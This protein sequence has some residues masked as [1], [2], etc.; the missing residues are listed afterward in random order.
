MIETI[1]SVTQAPICVDVN[2][3]W[4]DRQQALDM[5]YWL[6]DRGVVFVEQPLPKE[7]VDDTAW[8]TQHSPLPIIADE[9]LQRLPDV[10]KAYQV[11]SGVNVKLMKCTGMR[12]AYNMIQTASGLGMKIMI[13]CMT[14]TS[15]AVTAAAQL[16]PMAHWADLDGNLLINND[17]YEGVKVV[18]GKL[19]LP[20]RPGIGVVQLHS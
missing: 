12:E 17:V 1:R 20:D 14:E 9:F 8:L 13:G 2:Q 4:K 6:K 7:Q 3:G 11:Y 10:K 15:C 19:I 16:S 5:I 18:N